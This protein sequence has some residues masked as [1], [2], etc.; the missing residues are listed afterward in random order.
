MEV[1]TC[2]EM[3][4]ELQKVIESMTR[5]SASMVKLSDSDIDKRAFVQ[6]SNSRYWLELANQVREVIAELHYLKKEVRFSGDLP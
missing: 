6:L 5:V 3:A 2:R 1:S 4:D